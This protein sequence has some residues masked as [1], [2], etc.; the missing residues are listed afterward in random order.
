MYLVK[1]INPLDGGDLRDVH[2]K[3]LGKKVEVSCLE[4]N[5]DKMVI[6]ICN[7]GGTALTS[8]IQNVEEDETS[9][10]VYTNNTEYYFVKY[11]EE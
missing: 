1:E 8:R 6:S 3:L 4:K 9:I 11:R 10:R 7:N 5:V 2:K